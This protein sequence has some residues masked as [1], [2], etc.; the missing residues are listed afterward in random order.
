[1]KRIHMLQDVVRERETS[2]AARIQLD[3]VTTSS[4]QRSIVTL[5]SAHCEDRA[6][7]H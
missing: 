3:Q 1:M 4:P 5:S 7:K 6:A 2:E